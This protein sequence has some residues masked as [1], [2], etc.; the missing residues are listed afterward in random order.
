MKLA[1]SS[2]EREYRALCADY[3]AQLVRLRSQVTR[4]SQSYEHLRDKRRHQQHY[5]G[6]T[7]TKEQKSAANLEL[8]AE[9]DRVKCAAHTANTELEAA[10]ERV[11]RLEA[12]QRQHSKTILTQHMLEEFKNNVEEKVTKEDD[13]QYNTPFQLAPPEGTTQLLE[14]LLDKHIQQLKLDLQAK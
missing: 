8:K 9:V 4:I 2:R 13:S 11:A 14:Q 3:E 6:G 5:R 7:N 1:A 10:L 12:E